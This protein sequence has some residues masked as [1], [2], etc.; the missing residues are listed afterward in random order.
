MKIY[1][2]NKPFSKCVVLGALQKTMK[3]TYSGQ[4]SS[5][6]SNSSSQSCASL[7]E[8][9]SCALDKPQNILRF[10][11]SCTRTAGIKIVVNV[12]ICLCSIRRQKNSFYLLN[13]L[14]SW[15]PSPQQLC[16]HIWAIPQ[17]FHT[18]GKSHLLCLYAGLVFYRDCNEWFFPKFDSV[19]SYL[20]APSNLFYSP[21]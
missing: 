20:T 11:P 21:S 16:K 17:W 8:K 13:I 10:H 4:V 15:T 9:W 19:R 3:N 5:N 18:H 7:E 2:R 1:D 6:C 12:V 14:P